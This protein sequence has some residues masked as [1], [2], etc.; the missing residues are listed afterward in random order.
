MLVITIQRPL[1][2]FFPVSLGCPFS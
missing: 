2:L 1:W